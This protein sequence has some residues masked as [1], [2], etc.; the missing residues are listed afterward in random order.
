LL[1]FIAGAFFVLAFMLPNHYFPWGSFYNDFAMALS[2][3]CLMIAALWPLQR[4]PLTLPLVAGVLVLV[5]SIPL[6][7]AI[8]GLLYFNSDG[9]VAAFYLV[10]LALAY[11]AAYLLAQKTSPQQVALLLAWGFLVSAVLSVGVSLHQWLLLDGSIW[12][13]DLQPGWWFP[14]G[15]LGQRTN[16]ATLIVAAW[17]S[18]AY[19]HHQEK[20]GV[21]GSIVTAL[22]LLFGAALMQSRTVIAMLPFILLWWAW[23][24]RE[25][26]TSLRFTVLAALLLSF[27]VFYGLIPGWT[28]AFYIDIGEFPMDTQ[29]GV[30]SVFW[31]SLL[32][33]VSERP[34]FGYGWNEV[35]VAQ[36]SVAEL[37]Q[38]SGFTEHSHNL[39]IDL[40]VWNGF[41]LGILLIAALGYWGLSRTARCNSAES[42]FA[43]AV[44]GC[45]MIH[46]LL[47]FPLDYAYFLIPAGLLAGLVD[48]QY[49][50][51]YRFRCPAWVLA[52]V[53]VAGAIFLV[54]LF[55]ENGELEDDHREM[56]FA[57]A[58]IVGASPGAS[59]TSVVVL[60]GPR[61]FIRYALTEAK[62]E[63]TE[64]EIE[65]MRKVAY[66]NAYP[67]ALFRY[68]LA[69]A[70]NNKH[71]EACVVLQK[72]R[73]FDYEKTRYPEAVQNLK[74][75]EGSYPQ[76]VGM[77]SPINVPL[78]QHIDQ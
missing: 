12:L 17:A 22:F 44:I 38:G 54:V 31:S 73:S 42:W 24:G 62:P 29:L 58:G 33:A 45:V 21:T 40:L 1:K 5:A 9:W 49:P 55:K 15:N 71:D 48:A 8:T 69:L 10:G 13:V 63:M 51:K 53:T 50:H 11:S 27:V 64:E 25:D 35:A 72:L 39:L 70:F 41:P 66:R 75:M 14:Y 2:L 30:R 32:H 20:L 18:L 3:L 16:L 61:E 6:L 78:D 19:L 76:L 23:R 67:P 74:L 68:V 77:C 52:V 37:Y 46:S 26:R 28:N 47:E 56:R 60:D 43:L 36:V 57:S 34:W 65:W 59:L 4:R 7:Q